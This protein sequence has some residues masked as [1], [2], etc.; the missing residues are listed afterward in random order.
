VTDTT[1]SSLVV[2][3]AAVALA[4]LLADLVAP[5]IRIPA[6]VIEILA[7]ILI[8]PALGWAHDDAIIDFLSQLGL[9]T[10]MFLA[11]LEID[12][13]RIRGGPLRRAVTGWGVTFVAALGLGAFVATIDGQDAVQSGFL[14]GLAVTTTAF[15]ILLPILR[16]S[17]ELA[18]QFGT[19]VLA[20][21]AIGELGPIVAIAVLFGTDA[22]GRT[23]LVLIAFVAVVLLASVL[24]QREP[25]M[26]LARIVSATLT[27]SGQVAIRLSILFLAVMVWL[28][29]E[30]G[31][32]VLLGAFAAGMVTN[33]IASGASRRSVELFESKLNGIGFGFVVP[34]FFVV[35]GMKFDLDSIFDDPLIIVVGPAF[36]I[37]FLVLRGIPAAVT[38]RSMPMRDRV[39]F[40][41]YLAT[42]LP[43]VVV[44]TAIGVDTNRLDSSTAAALVAA[45]MVSVLCYP[46]IAA[47][48]RSGPSAG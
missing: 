21:S 47:R 38:T 34:L 45:A 11:G 40:A 3:L 36:L 32:D 28:A 35:S 10:L 8:G 31:L 48:V 7:G 26:R 2:I 5:V 44:I 18:T 39:A 29:D 27:T 37:A 24:A 6:V 19:E 15:G 43:L 1:L 25:N 41:F 42:Q 16:D 23:V 30:L 13:Q 4:P 20:G 12:L 9:C 46:L 14:V 33:L 17:G 22:P